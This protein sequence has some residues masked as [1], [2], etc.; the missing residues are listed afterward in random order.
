MTQSVRLILPATK[1]FRPGSPVDTFVA[2]TVPSELDGPIVVKLVQLNA[3]AAEVPLPPYLP[4]KY[5]EGY[6][7][8][9]AGSESGVFGGGEIN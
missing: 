7:Q 6:L 5:L 8:G 9:L 1:G 4:L 2:E 3:M